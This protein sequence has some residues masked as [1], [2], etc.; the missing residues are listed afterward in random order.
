MKS[1]QRFESAARLIWRHSYFGCSP[2]K[3]SLHP[4]PPQPPSPSIHHCQSTENVRLPQHFWT[5]VRKEYPMSVPGG[6]NE[7]RIQSNTPE[8]KKRFSSYKC[9]GQKT[10]VIDLSVSVKSLVFFSTIG[11]IRLT[12]RG[13]FCRLLWKHFS[14]TI[15]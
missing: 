6:A 10:Q 5:I 12:T 4:S 14:R 1:R 15:K 8:K 13:C 3:K 9:D 7:K 11:W 2:C